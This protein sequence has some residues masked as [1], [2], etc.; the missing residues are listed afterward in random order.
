MTVNV[1]HVEISPQVIHYRVKCKVS[2]IVLHLS[3]AYAFHT[4]ASKRQL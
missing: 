4:V 2:S 1:F 3:Y